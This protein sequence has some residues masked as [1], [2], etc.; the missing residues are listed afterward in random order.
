MAK[1][2]KTGFAI[3]GMLS[4]SPMSGYEIRQ[5]MQKSTANFW[6]ES[7]GQLYPA[8][9]KLVT[10]GL[11]ICQITDTTGREKKIYTITKHGMTELNQWLAEE[12]ETNSVR[13]EFMLKLFFSA[14]QPPHLTLEHVHA[15]RYKTQALL[16]QLNKTTKKLQ[17]DDA[18]SHHLPYWLFAV[19]YGK[20]IAEAKLK[21]CDNVIT[22]LKKLNVEQ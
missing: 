15:Y 2:T 5:L 8:L 19:D 14:N 9:A 6:S 13:N 22:T 16:T 7:D 4:I 21:W 18:E 10:A 3:L 1:T 12:A 20:Q 17:Q 11:L